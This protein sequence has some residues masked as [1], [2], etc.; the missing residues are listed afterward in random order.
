VNDSQLRVL[1]QLFEGRFQSLRE[2][3]DAAPEKLAKTLGEFQASVTKEISGTIAEWFDADVEDGALALIHKQIK[4]GMEAGLAELLTNQQNAI[5]LASKQQAD[6][7]M[8]T[9]GEFRDQTVANRTMARSKAAV[10]G[11]DFEAKCES[12]M[13]GCDALKARWDVEFTGNTYGKGRSKSGDFLLAGD[14]YDLMIECKSDMTMTYSRAILAGIDGMKNRDAALGL[15]LV[16]STKA[17][18]G[19]G[20]SLQ[21]DENSEVW[22]LLLDPEAAG[23]DVLLLTTIDFMVRAKDAILAA[24]AESEDA[25][26]VFDY[27]AAMDLLNDLMGDINRLGESINGLTSIRD[28]MTARIESLM[29]MVSEEE[30]EE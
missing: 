2:T 9:I 3:L 29:D 23:A 28:D 15:V 5:L 18:F 19:R 20:R 6:Q 30:E 24:E 25:G 21:Y 17:K 16:D 4:S 14:E 12:L 10:I 26:D 11:A 1:N 7:L 27:A 8:R 22:V 13:N